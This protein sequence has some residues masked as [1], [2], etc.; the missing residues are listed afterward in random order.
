[1][2]VKWPTSRCAQ[3]VLPS[4]GTSAN[5][6][7]THPEPIHQCIHN[8]QPSRS[9]LTLTPPLIC[10]IHTYYMNKLEKTVTSQFSL[11]HSAHLL[12]TNR[13]KRHSSV[14]LVLILIERGNVIR[15]LVSCGKKES[16]EDSRYL[17]SIY[18]LNLLNSW[19][20]G[21]YSLISDAAKKYES[22]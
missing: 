1:M 5:A 13:S 14:S 16:R 12:Y 7:R 4:T 19:L 18:S 21:S 6:S 11:V 2:C 22:F 15:I 20:A 9:S 8:V 3:P 17:I 10:I